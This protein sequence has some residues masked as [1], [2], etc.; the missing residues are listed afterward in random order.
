PTVELVALPAPGTVAAPPADS[1][2][3]AQAAPQHLALLRGSAGAATMPIGTGGVIGRAGGQV[4]FVLDHPHV[5]RRH[6]R[7]LVDGD[8]VR[9]HDLGSA[10]GTFV[11]GRRLT[12][13]VVLTR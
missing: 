7:L 5:S 2:A 6:A 4:E 9:L 1:G 8:R 3:T 11:N 10:N 12:E 13:P